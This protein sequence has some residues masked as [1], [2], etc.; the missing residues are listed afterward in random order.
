MDYLK[1][2]G[3]GAI[4]ILVLALSGTAMGY[5]IRIILARNLSIADYGLIYSILSFVA[6]F[7]M[8]RDISL[9]TALLKFL[10]EYLVKN[11]MD[12]FRQVTRYTLK[13]QLLMALIISFLIILFARHISLLYFKSETAYMPL[14]LIELSFLISTF[15]SFF[16]TLLQAGGKIFYFAISEPLR[17]FSVL[18]FIVVFLPLGIISVGYAYLFASIILVLVLFLFVKKSLSIFGPASTDKNNTSDVLSFGVTLFLG[19]FAGIVLNYADTL[20]LTALKPLN[21]VGLYQAALPTS[22]L[23]WF[24]VG[25]TIPI[26]VP[27]VSKFASNNMIGSV[28]HGVELL[29]KS[30]SLITA[31]FAVIFVTMPEILI[32]MTFGAKYVNASLALQI[33]AIG[34]IF[35]VFYT[36][37]S[38]TLIGLGKAKIFTKVFVITSITNVILDVF[39]INFFG[40]TG[41]SI[42]N[43]TA[44]LVGGI[45]CYR[46]LSNEIKIKINMSYGVKLV[47]IFI[48]NIIIISLIK[49]MFNGIDGFILLSIISLV[50]FYCLVALIKPLSRDEMQKIR[51]SEILPRFMKILII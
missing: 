50:I 20:V 21:D 14:I 19:S 31:A 26:L 13:I 10:P 27:T 46:Y 12:V 15:L 34:S 2:S 3:R 29:I 16:Q 49:N 5:L 32:S 37:L 8:F 18:V 22:Q 35:Y 51:S 9:N 24:F 33:L 38:N 40:V 30:M 48:S 39:L 17:I 36:A 7:T 42:A 23:L 44:Y 45:I 41:A 11:K 6:L 1:K 4:L 25:S 43:A 28:K 47:F